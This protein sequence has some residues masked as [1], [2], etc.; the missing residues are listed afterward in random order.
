MA[1][2]SSRPEAL[3]LLVGDDI[4]ADRHAGELG[5]AVVL[6]EVE[7]TGAFDPGKARGAQKLAQELERE[8]DTVEI[9]RIDLPA[10][11]HAHDVETLVPVVPPVEKHAAQQLEVRNADL[12]RRAL[13]E[14]AVEFRQRTRQLLQ[15]AQML[16]DMGGVDLVHG[17]VGEGAQVAAVA[18]IID[19]G[20]GLHVENF[21]ARL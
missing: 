3:P 18:D 19:I 6:E 9:V 4:E 10:E 5:S 13:L 17:L 20:S 12:G 2:I 8:P 16:E 11:R 7:V 21:P 1:T 15:I 14:N